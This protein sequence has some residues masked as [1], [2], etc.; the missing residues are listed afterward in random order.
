MEIV[1]TSAW[2][3]WKSFQRGLSHV[4]ITNNWSSE[5]RIQRVEEAME[6]W[7]RLEV[8]NDFLMFRLDL[9]GLSP[10]PSSVWHPQSNS[11]QSINHERSSSKVKLLPPIHSVLHLILSRELFDQEHQ[12]LNHLHHS[13]I[14]Q[15]YGYTVDQNYALVEHSDLGDLFTHLSTSQTISY[16][17]LFLSLRLEFS[18]FEGKTV[19]CLWSLNCPMRC[20]ISNR[21]GWFIAMSLQ[22][23]AWFIPTT[24][25]NWPTPRWHQ[26]NSSRITTRSIIA[27]CR[28]DG[29]HRSRLPM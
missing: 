27:D 21:V 6:R 17:W 16:V 8:S 4:G 18:L 25:L 23:I 14:A 9:S 5:K 10:S 2:V 12:L 13:N 19:V 7:G 11:D 26:N 22:G 3:R 29:W 28:S 24:R 15:F 1:R 20:A